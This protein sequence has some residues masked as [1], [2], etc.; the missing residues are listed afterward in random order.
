MISIDT[1][2]TLLGSGLFFAFV[3]ETGCGK[4]VTMTWYGYW[5]NRQINLGEPIT[6]YS[7]YH[8]K[9]IPEM[10]LHWKYTYLDH[11]DKMLEISEGFVFADEL[12]GWCLDSYQTKRKAQNQY[13][14]LMGRGRKR[15]LGIFAS[16]QRFLRLDPNFRA[17]VHYLVTPQMSWLDGKPY[18]IT[19]YVINNHTEMVEGNP[20]IINPLPIFDM[21]DTKEEIKTYDELQHT[22]FEKLAKEFWK[23]NKR[24]VSTPQ[25][26]IAIEQPCTLA[27]VN[28][29]LE[30]KKIRFKMSREECQMVYVA[31]LRLRDF[32]R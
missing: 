17:N 29:F 8:F 22:N 12:W 18:E 31:C 13:D 19:V 1:I 16:S 26:M 30:E 9:D 14:K 21:Y 4:T 27:L 2:N 6:L 24:D 5:I 25:G 3:G 32:K 11:P 20:F 23:W 28:L 10:G 15:G 7:N